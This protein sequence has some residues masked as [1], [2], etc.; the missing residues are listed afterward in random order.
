MRHCEVDMIEIRVPA[1]TANLGP[2]FDCLGLALSLYNTFR[3]RQ[4]D[5]NVLKGIP[6]EF[7]GEDNLFLRAFRH[8]WGALSPGAP[9]D[10]GL[11]SATD[12]RLEGQSSVPA[13]EVEFETEIPPAR[14]LGSSAALSA[15]GAAAAL[16]LL[17]RQRNAEPF[18]PGLGENHLQ[19][20]SLNPAQKQFI[21]EMAA[22][23]EGHP[24]NAAPA[25][26]GGFTA[27]AKTAHRIHVSGTPVPN[28]WIFLACIPDYILET[29]VARAA[30]PSHYSRAD[31]THA[32]AHA[33][34][35][36]L[37]IREGDLDALAEVCEDRIH[38][39]YRSA[40]IPGYNHV[41]DVLRSAGAKAIWLSGSGPTILGVFESETIQ[42]PA[43]RMKGVSISEIDAELDEHWQ[44]K[45]LSPDNTGLQVF[46]HDQALSP[47]KPETQASAGGQNE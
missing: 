35:T 21:L 10:L 6:P 8:A 33:T 14:G 40:L 24:D 36:A 12:A 18:K 45:A 11:P 39:P 19:Q 1:T 37:A 46:I 5:T 23:I 3:I 25:V 47:E 17:A 16:L 31:T 2:G 4:S 32:I 20:I 27:A 22:Y 15:A 13:L 9:G 34:L 28:H 29:S 43:A 7:S 44:V 30:L 42:Y 41:V 26:Y 38:Q